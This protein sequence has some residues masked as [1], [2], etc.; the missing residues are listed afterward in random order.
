M[1]N[2]I[3]GRPPKKIFEAYMASNTGRYEVYVL[4]VNE[5]KARAIL[6]RRFPR[7]II[8]SIHYYGEIYK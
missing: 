7:L 4:A 1:S 3:N 6:Q 5:E 8:G 2:H